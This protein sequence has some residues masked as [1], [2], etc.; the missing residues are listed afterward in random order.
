MHILSRLTRSR[1]ADALAL[2]VVLAGCTGVRAVVDPA[3]APAVAPVSTT[4]VAVAPIQP[5]AVAPVAPV[6]AY[7]SY[8]TAGFYH[9]N[10]PVAGPIGSQCTC[11]GLGGPSFGTVR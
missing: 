7:G 11:P 5:A 9:C 3:V 1:L 8:C 2:P 4:P 6:V 10:L